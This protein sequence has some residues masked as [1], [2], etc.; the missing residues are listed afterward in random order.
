M[1]IITIFQLSADSV[2]L[3]DG[4]IIT[5]CQKD[6]SPASFLLPKIRLTQIFIQE[7]ST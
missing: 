1:K 5:P 3:T 6:K 7:I 2:I 4:M